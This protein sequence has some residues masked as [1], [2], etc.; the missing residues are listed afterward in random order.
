MRGHQTWI[1]TINPPP[2]MLFYTNFPKIIKVKLIVVLD[3]LGK[4]LSC[5]EILYNYIFG[6]EGE[7]SYS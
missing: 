7:I 4:G 2:S 1:L 6:K 3:A 5:T